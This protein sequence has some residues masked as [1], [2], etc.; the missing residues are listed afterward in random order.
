M[1]FRV[2]GEKYPRCKILVGNVTMTTGRKKPTVWRISGE[3]TGVTPALEASGDFLPYGISAVMRTYHER[4]KS[5]FA[6]FEIFM[7]L[8]SDWDCLRQG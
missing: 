2:E 1:L 4:E 5:R 6:N 3:I 8:D 7:I